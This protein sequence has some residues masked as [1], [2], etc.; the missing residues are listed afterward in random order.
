MRRDSIINTERGRK[1]YYRNCYHCEQEEYLL[2]ATRTKNTT[3]INYRTG[4]KDIRDFPRTCYS[5]LSDQEGGLGI[6]APLSPLDPENPPPI[7]WVIPQEELEVLAAKALRTMRPR[8]SDLSEGISL[9]NFI[10]EMRDIKSMFKLWSSKLRGGLLSKMSK[11]VSGGVLNWSL[12]WKPFLGDLKKLDGLFRRVQDKIDIW[13]RHADEGVIHT[14]H[15]NMSSELEEHNYSTRDDHLHR[16]YS[17]SIV[18]DPVRADYRIVENQIVE[19]FFHM[20][21][22]PIRIESNA[23]IYDTLGIALDAVGAGQGASIVWEAV[24]FSFVID[25]FWGVGDFLEQFQTEATTVGFDIVDF[26][27]SYKY[28]LKRRYQYHEYYI[29]NNEITIPLG[30]YIQNKKWYVR[31]RVAAPVD[32]ID[33]VDFSDLWSFNLPSWKQSWIGLNLANA[34]R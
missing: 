13:N 4:V 6:F 18:G 2:A 8:I 20:Y 25:W 31:R 26:G 19:I 23:S 32:K 30:S 28:E 1:V 33:D 12:G 22:K 27:Y 17:N 7:P 5:W 9:V 34:L 14:R 21:Y 15:A 24:P 11:N 10:A 29:D 3:E 16:Q